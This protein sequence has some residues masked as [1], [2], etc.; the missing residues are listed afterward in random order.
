MG[1]AFR[2]CGI[3]GADAGIAA[4]AGGGGGISAEDAELRRPNKLAT[5][6][7]HTHR[8]SISRIRGKAV[9]SVPATLTQETTA[10]F[11]RRSGGCFPRGARRSS[12]GHRR[13]GKHGR[14]G[15]Q[16]TAHFSFVENLKASSQNT[17]WSFR[18]SCHGRNR[19]HCRA[20]TSTSSSSSAASP[21]LRRKATLEPKNMGKVCG[22]SDR[23]TD[24]GTDEPRE[25]LCTP[26]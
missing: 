4:A 7:Q 6:T 9:N 10:A 18:A 15:R 17:L 2:R 23:G 1:R 24:Q 14:H 8:G 26:V 12:A 13:A 20:H 21:R 25:L 3:K 11:R 16:T 22:E 19:A 5:H